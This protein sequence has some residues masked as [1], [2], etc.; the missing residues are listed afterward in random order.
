[1]RFTGSMTDRQWLLFLTLL[2]DVGRRT[3]RRALERQQVRRETPSEVLTL[4]AET[5]RAVYGLPAR[6]IRA[7]QE[8]REAR[9]AA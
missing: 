6:A 8:E 7:I 1:M 2:P 5:L 3:L 9:Q 4:P